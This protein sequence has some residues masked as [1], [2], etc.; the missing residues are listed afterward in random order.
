MAWLCEALLVS[1]SG[2][3][4]W[5]QRRHSPGPRQL[6]NVQLRQRIRE[7][8]AR[9]RETYGSP[10]LARA[11]GCPG[12]RNRIKVL[13]RV[14][15][16]DGT[17]PW[18]L[19]RAANTLTDLLYESNQLH[20]TPVV[21]FGNRLVLTS[22]MLLWNLFVC[23]L[24]HASLNAVRQR[25][26][27]NLTNQ[28]VKGIRAEFGLMFEGYVLWLFQE[29]FGDRPVRLLTNYLVRVDAAWRERDVA[30]IA[31]GVAFVFEVKGHVVDLDLRK[32][33]SFSGLKRLVGEP[34]EQAYLAAE[35]FLAGA[36]RTSDGRPV[37]AVDRVVPVALVYDP[38]PLSLFTGDHF[39]PWLERALRVPVFTPSVSRSGVLLLNVD[40]LEAAEVGLRLDRFPEQLLAAL[41]MRAKRPELRYEKLSS[42]GSAVNGTRRP[43]PVALLSSDT[44]DFLHRTGQAFHL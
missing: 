41:L 28:Q 26:A 1:R 22:T 10:R 44:D 17:Q 36:V 7:E 23:G 39:E 34:A 3:Y 6:E 37:P 20:A 21:S 31:D 43:A 13:L 8:F 9:S 32:S 29:W 4:D 19:T 18:N 12:R 30:V 5:L 35:A 27:G 11:L 2:Y 14:A 16:I 24:P 15:T 38:I 40:D 42:L 25:Q 33:G